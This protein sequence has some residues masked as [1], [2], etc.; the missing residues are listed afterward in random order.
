MPSVN[1]LLPSHSVPYYLDYLAVWYYL[2]VQSST[3]WLS[4]TWQ[5]Q[6]YLAVQ[7]LAVHVLVLILHTFL[8]SWLLSLLPLTV[9]FTSV[10][11]S[12][13]HSSIYILSH[14]SSILLQPQQGH[15]PISLSQGRIH[16]S[17]IV[18]QNKTRQQWYPG[19]Q[20]LLT[21]GGGGGWFF[22]IFLPQTPSCNSPHDSV[23][24]LPFLTV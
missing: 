17:Y 4:G 21:A 18:S 13:T 6:Y 15:Q 2:A 7:Y 20:Q 16:Y 24:V 14:S 1:A 11:F 12:F 3:T 19:Q 8:L 23:T 22:C 9:S 5:V 10:S